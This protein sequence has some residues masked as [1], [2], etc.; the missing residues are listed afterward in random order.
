MPPLSP[1]TPLLTPAQSAAAGGCARGVAPDAAALLLWLQ[2]PYFG[3]KSLNATDAALAPKL[4]HA[5]TAL[6]HFRVRGWLPAARASACA[7][8]G[9]LESR[10]LSPIPPPAQRAPC[11][12]LQLHLLTTP[13]HDRARAPAA[14]AAAGVR[15]PPSLQAGFAARVPRWLQGWE[16]PVDRFPGTAAYMQQLKQLPAWQAVDYGSDAIIKGWAP[17]VPAL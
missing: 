10:W 3:G 6:Q 11:R 7:R 1:A 14:P 4:Y 17:K 16:L 13:Q 9:H 12:R 15:C 5:F 8:P 2:G